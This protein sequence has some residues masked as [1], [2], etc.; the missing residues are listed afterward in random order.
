MKGRKS[1]LE[2]LVVVGGVVI[3]VTMMMM[4]MM[5]DVAKLLSGEV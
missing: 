3:A 1:A 5:V 2:F 4:M